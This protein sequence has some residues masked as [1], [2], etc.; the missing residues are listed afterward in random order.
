VSGSETLAGG[1]RS[2][3]TMGRQFAWSGGMHTTGGNTGDNQYSLLI[4]RRY[5]TGVTS[6]QTGIT[7]YLDG[8]SVEIIPDVTSLTY[9]TWT[10][11]V[12]WNVVISAI[13]GTAD[14]L[15]ASDT[16][17]AEDIII[18]KKTGSTVTVIESSLGT[19]YGS[20]NMKTGIA[21]GY[22]A[23]GT[24]FRINL[25]APTYTNSGTLTLKASADLFIKENGY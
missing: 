2:R 3:A 1:F 22:T 13:S 10:L 24:N 6:G 4:A 9:R 17:G 12:R 21:M 20:T 19:V 23:S 11:K 16:V 8:S 14:G 25:V 5:I 15:T 7:L 18:I